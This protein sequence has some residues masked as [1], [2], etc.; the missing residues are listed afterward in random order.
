[1]AEIAIGTNLEAQFP[2]IFG[3]IT[4]GIFQNCK[5]IVRSSD[6]GCRTGG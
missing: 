6:A 4:K 1:M 3:T 2:G 5:G